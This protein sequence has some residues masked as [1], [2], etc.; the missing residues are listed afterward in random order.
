M[1]HKQRV[2]QLL[3]DNEPHSHLEGYQLGV[4]LHSRVADLRRDGYTIKCWAEDGL[5]LYQLFGGVRENGNATTD[6][7]AVSDRSPG[8]PS[9]SSE[10]GVAQSPAEPR[11]VTVDAAEGRNTDE[12]LTGLGSR[13]LYVS[14]SD[15]DSVAAGTAADGEQPSTAAPPAPQTPESAGAPWAGPASPSTVGPAQLSVFEAA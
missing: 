13:S 4:M 14:G 12:R 15:S 3:S 1:T 10:P 5:Y 9:T 7:L 8:Q 11:P 6:G 2:L